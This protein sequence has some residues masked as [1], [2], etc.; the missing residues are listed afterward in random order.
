MKND[1]ASAVA[2]AEALGCLRCD[3]SLGIRKMPDG[4]ALMLNPDYSHFF[5]LRSDGAESAIHWNKWAIYRWAV[6]DAKK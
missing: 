2:E 5:L 4:Y 6:Q 3:R 1:L